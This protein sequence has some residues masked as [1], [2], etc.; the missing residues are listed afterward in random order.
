[1]HW[2]IG[3]LT[4]PWRRRSVASRNGEWIGSWFGCQSSST[5]KPTGRHSLTTLSAATASRITHQRGA[6]KTTTR[7]QRP[8]TGDRQELVGPK[9]FSCIACH[10][11]G[12]YVPKKAA[13][14]T[15][16]SDLVGLGNRMR[17]SYFVRWTRSPLRIVPGVEMP[18]YTKAVHGVL[19]DDADAQLETLWKT[20]AD[21]RFKPPTDPSSVEQYFVV[22]NGTPA[23]VIRDVSPTPKVTAED[24]FPEHSQSDSKTDTA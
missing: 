14:G 6:S 16:G 1:M 2:E 8:I 10:Q 19:G 15:R 22:E 7:N 13:M 3:C 21:S 20:L 23:R 5:A 12:D 24:T 4:R 11:V 18:S 9:G 17:H